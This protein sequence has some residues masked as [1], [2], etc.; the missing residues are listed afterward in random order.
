MAQTAR[1]KIDW[2]KLAIWV[3]VLTVIAFAIVVPGPTPPAPSRPCPADPVYVV[4]QPTGP[5]VVVPG[6]SPVRV[7][8]Q[9]RAVHPHPYLQSRFKRAAKLPA[10]IN[11]AEVQ[12]RIR[13][14]GGVAPPKEVV[15]AGARARGIPE[16]KV[17]QI[18]ACL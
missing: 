10:K 6:V 3:W 8:P 9:P 2:S 12:N 15:A 1:V 13:S 5:P 14:H 4:P 18:L 7:F 16:D 11:C 17:Q